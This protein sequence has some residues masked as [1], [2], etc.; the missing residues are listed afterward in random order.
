MPPPSIISR[1]EQYYT[2]N[3]RNIQNLLQN[4]IQ[5]RQNHE[6]AVYSL[7]HRED[8]YNRYTLNNYNN[9]ESDENYKW[10]R[11]LAKIPSNVER[12][13]TSRRLKKVFSMWMNAD[14]KRKYITSM[15]NYKD[16]Y[17]LPHMPDWRD[18]LRSSAGWRGWTVA[19]PHKPR[20]H[21]RTLLTF[22][23]MPHQT[24]TD[25]PLSRELMVNHVHRDM[26]PFY[27]SVALPVS[28]PVAST[29]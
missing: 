11:I 9:S 28:Q 19:G 17:N 10:K 25:P 12:V 7:Q 5:N 29:C 1:P 13:Y 21:E 22:A 16:F 18:V 8:V 15:L 3:N 4:R 6:I 24:E 2:N 27:Q 14:K 23:P 20:P 26:Q